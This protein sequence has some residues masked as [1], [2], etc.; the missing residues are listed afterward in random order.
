MALTI[1]HHLHSQRVRAE[2]AFLANETELIAY[3]YRQFPLHYG[4]DS[5]S[6]LFSKYIDCLGCIKLRPRTEFASSRQTPMVDAYNCQ[7]LTDLDP[8]NSRCI[9]V[10]VLDRPGH[11]TGRARSASPV[12]E[13]FLMKQ[14]AR[15]E[16][17]KIL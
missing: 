8:N 9:K 10:S 3:V 12:K 2:E 13:D 14:G 4:D 11:A 1:V 7:I 6:L 17:R 16:K 15:K 5:C